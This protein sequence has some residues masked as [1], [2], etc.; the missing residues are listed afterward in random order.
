MKKI[1]VIASIFLIIFVA[2][3]ARGDGQAEQE[4]DSGE[5]GAKDYS[6]PKVNPS[7]LDGKKIYE[8]NC[9]GCHGKEGDGLGDLS[10]E[11]DPKP[12]DFN[13]DLTRNAKPYE[14]FDTVSKGKDGTAM[15]AWKDE[16]NEVSIWDVVF[17]VWTYRTD[18]LDIDDGKETYGIECVR[19]HGEE[20]DGVGAYSKD[21]TPPPTDFTDLKFMVGKSDNEF[22][23]SVF[24][25]KEGTGMKAFGAELGNEKVTHAVDYIRSFSYEF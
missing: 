6:F 8:M 9:I 13:R 17:Y 18:D 10:A 11:L 12:A 7:A 15:Q 14:Y 5:Q 4:G 2:G 19:C 16:M 22:Y 21:Y 3:C 20:G 23:T 25:G 1:L 24:D